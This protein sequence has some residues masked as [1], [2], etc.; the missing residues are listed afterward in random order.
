M[1]AHTHESDQ[2]RSIVLRR[3]LEDRRREI[4]EKLRSLLD[5]LP[6]EASVVRDLEEQS[7]TDFV[8]EVDFTL[9]QMK[10][11]TLARIDEA[12]RRLE[13][14]AYGLCSDCGR[15][16]AQARLAALPFAVR[17]REC[18]ERREAAEATSDFREDTGMGTRLREGM[19]LSTNHEAKHE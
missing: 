19:A 6:D 2:E 13:Q 15:P 7:V 12:L 18:Q 8:Q 9:M 10:S 3:M 14:G 1:T 16:I 5:T 11:E 4:Q 17:C